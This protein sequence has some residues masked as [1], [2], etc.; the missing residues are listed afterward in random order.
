[1]ETLSQMWALTTVMDLSIQEVVSTLYLH[2]YASIVPWRTNAGRI[3]SICNS[4]F[5][6]GMADMQSPALA[7]GS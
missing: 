4:S 6:L 7:F 5:H 2:N 3:K 1:M